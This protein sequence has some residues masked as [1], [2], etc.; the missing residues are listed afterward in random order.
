MYKI[1]IVDHYVTRERL[2]NV[3]VSDSRIH[4]PESVLIGSVLWFSIGERLDWTRLKGY[5]IYTEC[6]APLDKS[7]DEMTPDERANRRSL[8]RFIANDIAE[9]DSTLIVDAV[10]RRNASVIWVHIVDTDAESQLPEFFVRFADSVCVWR[11]EPIAPQ[12]PINIVKVVGVP[13]QKHPPTYSDDSHHF[14]GFR[15]GI[16]GQDGRPTPEQIF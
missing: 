6:D 3:A 8:G 12:E 15:L 13:I 7:H 16:V 14:F 11:F 2:A 4:D 10:Q 5:L 9:S 1:D